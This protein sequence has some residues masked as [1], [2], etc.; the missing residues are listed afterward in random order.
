MAATDEPVFS[1][2]E[3]GWNLHPLGDLTAPGALAWS[4]I[5][6]EAGKA[7]NT[8]KKACAFCRKVY[9]QGPNVISLHLDARLKPRSILACQPE[10]RWVQRHTEVVAEIRK[11]NS[12]RAAKKQPA[13][14]KQRAR[15]RAEGA[16][17]DMTLLELAATKAGNLAH[18][19]EVNAAWGKAIIANA[20]PL[21]LVDS[22]EFRKAV[23][24][25]ARA[26]VKYF[27][28]GEI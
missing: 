26:G 11:Q 3:T 25:T 16:A 19:V 10:A 4:T 28:G 7:K 27:S 13:E 12:E 5:E 17:K 22:E 1:V 21:R 23:E 2:A 9:T 15:L 24:L 14:D 20:L 8:G 6:A 18:P